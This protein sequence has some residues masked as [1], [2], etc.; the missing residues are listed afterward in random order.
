MRLESVDSMQTC[1]GYSNDVT[2]ARSLPYNCTYK[3]RS[4][5]TIQICNDLVYFMTAK[6]VVS[7]SNNFEATRSAIIN[8]SKI[9]IASW[10][11]VKFKI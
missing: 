7:S 8:I 4:F 2:S 11:N 5:V 9:D 10:Q 6:S 3:Q 1:H